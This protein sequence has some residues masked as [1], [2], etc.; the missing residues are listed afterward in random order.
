MIF[1]VLIASLA[2]TGLTAVAVYTDTIDLPFDR[3]FSAKE[4][5]Q[6]VVLAQPCIPEG[7]LPVPYDTIPVNVL[8]ATSQGGL[9][10]SASSSL[11]DRGFTVAS[12]GNTEVVVEGIRISFGLSGLA[13]AYTVAAHFED[14]DL[15]YDAREDASV[16]VLLGSS[17]ET[18]KAPEAV[19]L[20]PTVPMISREGCVAINEITPQALPLVASTEEPAEDAP[21]D[22]APAEEVPAG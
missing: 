19:T 18:V 15:Y 2:V 20:D 21:A 1:G 13:S 12:T 9:A 14:A 7:T 16:D 8:N 4:V 6:D 10:A 17:F 22:E 3:G 11:A 5:K